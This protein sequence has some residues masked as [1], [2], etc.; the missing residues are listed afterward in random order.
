MKRIIMMAAAGCA[1][2]MLTGCGVPQEEH[3]AKIAEL[4]SAWAEIETLKGSVTDLESL[5]KAEKGKTRNS[6]IELDAASKRITELT[7]KEAAA[8]NALADEKGKISELESQLAAATSATGMAEDRTTEAEAAL[9]ALQVEY[10]KLQA[11]FDQFQKNMR[12]LSGASTP[13]AAPKTDGS[14][15]SD[16]ETALNLLDEMSMQ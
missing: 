6:R 7:A 4:N 13:A 2:G 11:R 9:A 10:D 16:S 12:S 14:A 8:A 3:D 5:L 1:V 15:K